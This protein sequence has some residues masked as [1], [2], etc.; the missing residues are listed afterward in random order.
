M[1]MA[2]NAFTVTLEPVG[3]C[4]L[5]C[6]YCYSVQH[7]QTTLLPDVARSALEAIAAYAGQHG[8]EEL[9]CVWLGGEPLLAGLHF[10]EQVFAVASTLALPLRH[11]L[12]T[13]GLL[14]DE[15]FCHLFRDASVN[16]GISIDGPRAIHDAFRVSFGCQP[17]HSRVMDAIA[18][19]RKHSV[20]FGCVAVVSRATLG[21]EQEVY[22]FFRSLG[23]AFRINPVIPGRHGRDPI[24]QVKP[25]E[26]GTALVRFFDAWIAAGPAQIDI[27]PLDSYVAAVASGEPEEC[28][29][30]ESC[31]NR[32]LGIKHDGTVTIC[33]RF[34]NTLLGR[35]GST[36]V[37]E[38]LAAPTC[39]ALQARAS[40]LKGC[41]GCVDW[42]I[43]HGGCPH[44]AV[45]F[46]RGIQTKD[47]FC[48]AY[49]AIFRH[50]RKWLNV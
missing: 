29:H 47:P 37:A 41:H 38:L 25:A 8:F 16:V 30:Q 46:G 17:T 35:L 19:L 26:Y 34:Q 11:F 6:R 22:D 31:A 23:S 45:A 12:Q 27:S 2:V 1:S 4:N 28:Q 32:T 18:L 48:P 13:N 14:L 33:G 24:C 5:N 10:F 43:C 42:P 21:R 20:P 49:K 50:I 3:T 9:H 15:D 40:L 7:S 36:S 44:N 39:S